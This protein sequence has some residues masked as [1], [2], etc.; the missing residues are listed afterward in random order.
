[1]RINF[2]GGGWSDLEGLGEMSINFMGGG[3]WE[4]KSLVLYTTVILNSNNT[5]I[6]IIKINCDKMV[7]IF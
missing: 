5:Y 1:M 7:I 4:L 3:W 6:L 2:V